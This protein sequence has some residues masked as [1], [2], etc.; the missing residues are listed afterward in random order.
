MLTLSWKGCHCLPSNLNFPKWAVGKANRSWLFSP[1]MTRMQ[2][3]T[4][5]KPAGSLH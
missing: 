2:R 1:V 3:E 4:R 5:G